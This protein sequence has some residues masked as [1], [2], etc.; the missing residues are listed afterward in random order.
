MR[1]RVP[2]YLMRYGARRP[3]SVIH[4]LPARR[5]LDV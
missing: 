3:G 4:W 2:L 1:F 5:A